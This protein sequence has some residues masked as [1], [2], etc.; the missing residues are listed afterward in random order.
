LKAN[1]NNMDYIA[2]D[3]ST[4]IGRL[5]GGLQI[6]GGLIIILSGF[7]SGTSIILGLGVSMS[8][9]FV[10]ILYNIAEDAKKSKFYL[11]KIFEMQKDNY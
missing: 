8:S 3:N 4:I 5:V 2:N 7:G 9:V 6:I 1:E 10:F 11:K